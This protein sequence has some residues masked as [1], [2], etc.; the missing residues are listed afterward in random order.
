MGEGEWPGR[1]QGA[2][3]PRQW[4]KVHVGIEAESLEIRAIE[5]TGRRV[6]DGPLLPKRLEQVPPEELI[7]TVAA[8]GAYDTRVCQAAVAARQ[9]T[10]VMPTRRNGRPWKETTP[11]APG[12]KREPAGQSPPQSGDLAHL[13]RLPPTKPRRGQDA[14]P[15]APR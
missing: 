2:S 9:A 4:C 12:K 8:D 11:G 13:E 3:R 10:A 1:K 5:V 14:V 6:G 15:Q 7:G